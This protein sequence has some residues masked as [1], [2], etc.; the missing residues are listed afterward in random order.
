MYFLA[1]EMFCSMNLPLI[2]SSVLHFAACMS[3]V[4]LLWFMPCQEMLVNIFEQI[5]SVDTAFV[6]LSS[7][8]FSA[9]G[10]LKGL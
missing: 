1:N 6:W 2:T 7:G 9:S 5:I 10:V 3:I 4:Q 8:C